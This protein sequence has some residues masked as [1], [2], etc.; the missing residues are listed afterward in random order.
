MRNAVKHLIL[1]WITNTMNKQRCL[2]NIYVR[3]EMQA[4]PGA[5]YQAYAKHKLH[6]ELLGAVSEACDS[7]SSTD[8]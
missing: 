6:I 3:Q 8:F 4:A 5:N 1:P 7:R 2:Q